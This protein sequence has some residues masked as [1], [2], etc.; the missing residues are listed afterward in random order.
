MGGRYTTQQK[1]N[2]LYAWLKA[3]KKSMSGLKLF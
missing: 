1:I 3:L 2:G